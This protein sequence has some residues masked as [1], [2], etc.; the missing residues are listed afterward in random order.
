VK[1]PWTTETRS[2][3]E[4]AIADARVAAVRGHLRVLLA[5]LEQTLA[6][7]EDKRRRGMPGD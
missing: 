2:E 7:I 5:E 6:R 1:L 4:W 3:E